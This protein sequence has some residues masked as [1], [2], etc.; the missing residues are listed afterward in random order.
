MFHFWFTCSGSG[1]TWKTFLRHPFPVP[2]PW[3]VICSASVHLFRLS[4]TLGNIP[5]TPPGAES[6]RTSAYRMVKLDNGGSIQTRLNGYR[7]L[8]WQLSRST[9]TNPLRYTS[10]CKHGFCQVHS[11]SNVGEDEFTPYVYAC[12]SAYSEK[13]FSD[14]AILT[15]HSLKHTRLVGSSDWVGVGHYIIC[16]YVLLSTIPPWREPWQLPNPS[17][18]PR[19]PPLYLWILLVWNC[20]R[21]LE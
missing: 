11:S 9:A 20:K 16:C 21:L 2:E 6:T 14:Q 7:Y 18:C 19:L 4:L 17:W 13:F 10:Q 1:S 3:P 5:F 8:F 15:N 12:I